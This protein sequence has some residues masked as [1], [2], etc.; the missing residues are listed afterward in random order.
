MTV[1][2][3][4]NGT[5]TKGGQMSSTINDSRRQTDLDIARDGVATRVFL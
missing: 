4:D 2:N 5:A 1:D 3:T